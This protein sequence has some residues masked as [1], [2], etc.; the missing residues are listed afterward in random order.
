MTQ[1]ND[2]KPMF[3]DELDFLSDFDTVPFEIPLLGGTVASGEHA[4]NALKKIDPVERTE[5]PA[6]AT[7]GRSN[8]LGRRRRPHRTPSA[9]CGPCS[10]TGPAA[11]LDRGEQRIEER[12]TDD[13][14]ATALVGQRASTR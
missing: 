13:Y 11:S 3:R 9:H 4:F 1:T 12:Y 10:G 5:I 7:P 14:R 2:V 8:R 6:A